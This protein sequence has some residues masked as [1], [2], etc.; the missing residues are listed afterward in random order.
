M[1]Q[2]GQRDLV[3]AVAHHAVTMRNNAAGAST[4]GRGPSAQPVARR[5]TRPLHGPIA[6]F[7][8]PASNREPAEMGP[9]D[10]SSCALAAR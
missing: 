4:L 8:T 9:R 3:Q 6:S 1:A 5:P 10:A 7:R 2:V